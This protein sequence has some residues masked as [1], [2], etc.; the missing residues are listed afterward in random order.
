MERSERLKNRRDLI[1]RTASLLAAPLPLSTTLERFS[2]L[3]SS[4]VDAQYAGV[5]IRD[6]SQTTIEYVFEIGAGDRLESQTELALS[7]GEPVL[8]ASAIVVPIPFGIVWP[9]RAPLGSRVIGR[10][11]G[12]GFACRPDTA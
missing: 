1:R 3:L 5:A 8:S 6:E 12:S 9:L 2:Q 7:S 4:F 10:W 11:G